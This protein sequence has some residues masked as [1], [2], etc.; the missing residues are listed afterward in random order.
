MSDVLNCIRGNTIFAGLSTQELAAIEKFM[1]VNNVEAGD[2]VFNEGEKGDYVCFVASGMLDVLKKNSA[3]LQVV[4]TAI[5]AGN[6]I[7]EMA[8][9]DRQSRSAS[10]RA[11][12]TSSLVV[13]TRKGFDMIIRQHPDIAIRILINIAQKLSQNIRSTSERLAEFMLPIA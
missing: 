6:S 9:I 8:L 2:C 3:G 7:G 13:L 5:Q 11:R 1:F 10:V 4:I 12:E